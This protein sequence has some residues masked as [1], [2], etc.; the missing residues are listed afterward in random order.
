M[1]LP[2][3][4]VSVT[5]SIESI[6]ER[7]AA[8]CSLLFRLEWEESSLRGPNHCLLIPLIRAIGKI[9]GHSDQRNPY[10]HWLTRGTESRSPEGSA[11]FH[12]GDL[13]PLAETANAHSE[14]GA[15]RDI[16]DSLPD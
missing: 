9:R 13:T 5:R 2:V 12:I 3:R 8:F 11:D 1:V 10:S 7:R 4:I 16:D 6:S 14:M 15:T